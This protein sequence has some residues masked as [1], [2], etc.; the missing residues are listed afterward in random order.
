MQYSKSNEKSKDQTKVQWKVQSSR[1]SPMKSPK[2]NTKSNEKPKPKT[3]SNAQD[4]VQWKVQSQRQRPSKSPKPK[5]K[6]NAQNK[7]QW[8]NEKAE[9]QDKDKV[10]KKI[11]WTVE[12]PKTTMGIQN[13]KGPARGN[14]TREKTTTCHMQ[15][16]PEMPWK[17][18]KP[19]YYVETTVWNNLNFNLA[20][21][22][23][24]T[25][26]NLLKPFETV[27]ISLF[28]M[29][30]MQQRG[31]NSEFIQVKTCEHFVW[32][33]EHFFKILL[34][35]RCRYGGQKTMNLNRNLLVGKFRVLES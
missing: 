28:C 19:V 29:V 20:W 7:V 12:N 30:R 6:S 8:S 10:Q 27:W 2:P 5:A 26:W 25:Y 9:A 4:K 24:E 35:L 31:C 3:K 17:Q 14:A 15:K 1:Q 13:H 34:M 16:C 11:N 32:A 33:L 21:K 23:F 18:P 22:L